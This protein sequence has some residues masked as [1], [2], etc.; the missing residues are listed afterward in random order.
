MIDETTTTTEERPC[1][2]AHEDAGGPCGE[3]AA[4]GVYGLNF[5]KA[6]GEEVRL[7][8]LLEEQHEVDTFLARF[9]D[10]PLPI[11]RVLSRLGEAERVRDSD[12]WAALTRIYP[13][14]PEDV[15]ERVDQ[16]E[17]DEEHGG[18]AVLD[19]LLDNLH[20]L[21]KLLRISQE[22]GQPW[23]VELLERQRE[24]LA[25]EAAYVLERAE[26]REGVRSEWRN[27]DRAG[28]ILTGRPRPL[29]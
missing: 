4:I 28:A 19:C 3:P 12:Y 27:I 23:V 7:G 11:D 5:C 21:H 22:E 26:T 8:A 13:N 25:A 24:S 1:F 29:L 20:A 14:V 10:F 15:R 17:R 9:R 2:V 18:I 6:H 16:W